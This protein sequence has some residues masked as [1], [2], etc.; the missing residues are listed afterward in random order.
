MV[1]FGQLQV[2]F[3][4]LLFGAPTMYTHRIVVISEE[5]SR[6][7]PVVFYIFRN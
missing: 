5:S 7:Q 3:L 2:S 1:Q 4:D 6:E